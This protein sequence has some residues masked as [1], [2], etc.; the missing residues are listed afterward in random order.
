MGN[1]E[2]YYLGFCGD[3]DVRN[4]RTMQQTQVLP[5]MQETWIQ[6][7]GQEDTLQKDMAPHSNILAWG[8]PWTEKPGRLQSVGSQTDVTDFQ[9]TAQHMGI[10]Y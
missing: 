1:Y 6:S 10:I 5:V 2:H 4:P 8:I 7:L 3:S 9:S